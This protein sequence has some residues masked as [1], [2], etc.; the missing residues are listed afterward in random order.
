M[1]LKTKDDIVDPLCVE[2]S[3]WKQAGVPVDEVRCDN[4]GEN[5]AFVKRANTHC[6]LS[7]CP[8]CTAARTPQQHVEIGFSRVGA[9]GKAVMFRADVP[10]DMKHK[11]VKRALSCATKLDNPTFIEV[12]SVKNTRHM[13]WHWCGKN[14][15]WMH[16]LRVWGEAGACGI[17]DESSTPTSSQIHQRQT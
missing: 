6:K 10:G 16:N 1:T 13:H 4:G 8:E 11:F 5:G 15:D 14:P 9:E 17:T 3:L 2:F 7:I 12:D